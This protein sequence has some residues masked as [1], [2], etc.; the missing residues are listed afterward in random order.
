MSAILWIK[1]RWSSGESRKMRSHA[2][3]PS[4][5]RSRN[6][7]S[8]TASQTTAV[9]G[10]LRRKA[11]AAR[12]AIGYYLFSRPGENERLFEKPGFRLLNMCDATANA[13]R[14][15]ERWREARSRERR[16]SS[17]SK[18]KKT[19]KGCRVRSKPSTRSAAC[20]AASTWGKNRAP[21]NGPARRLGHERIAA[22]RSSSRLILSDRKL[23]NSLS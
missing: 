23:L 18:A 17:Q 8:W 11:I 10:R 5:V 20:C 13:Q 3:T 22:F 2:R 1:C 21:A 15:A 4:K 16:P 12:S 9:F 14:T 19:S 7:A 6:V